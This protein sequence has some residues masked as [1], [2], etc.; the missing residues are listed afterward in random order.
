MITMIKPRLALCLSL[1]LIAATSRPALACTVFV[2]EGQGELVVGR[3]YDWSFGEGMAVVNKRGQK[4]TALEYWGERG[5]DRLASW[6][7][8][9]GSVTFTQYGRDIAFAGINEAGLS[10]HEQWLDEASYP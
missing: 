1:V 3:S 4:K 2:V 6:T 9:Y 5:S 7:S 10:V 8:R